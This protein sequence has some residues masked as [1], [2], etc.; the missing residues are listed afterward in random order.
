MST[1]SEP[2]TRPDDPAPDSAVAPAGGRR[3]LLL[4]TLVLVTVVVL[5][6]DQLTK[7]WAVD[8]LVPGERVAVLGHLFGLALIRNPGAALSIGTGVTWVLTIMA[9]AVI[10]V[11]VRASRRIGSTGWALALGLLLGGALGNLIDRLAREPS[12]GRGEVVDFLA[13]GNVF[14]GNVAD[15]AIVVAAG[16]IVL[17]TVRG[18]RIDGTR[19]GAVDG[20]RE[21][22]ADGTR[23][24]AQDGST[25][26][27]RR[28][29]Q[30]VAEGP[31]D[32]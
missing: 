22:S 3:R 29:D 25:A 12:V 14:V 1:T 26:A 30:S 19:E 10:V 32:V 28:G 7:L 6:T 18:I 27:D 24:G 9:C 17:L 15:I 21:G 31:T 5:A 20:T 4:A 8:S 11:I 23:E 13:Y 16:L 2:P